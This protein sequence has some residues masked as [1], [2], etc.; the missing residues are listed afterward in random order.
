MLAHDLDFS[1][2]SLRIDIRCPQTLS[3]KDVGQP[4]SWPGSSMNYVK[5]LSHTQSSDGKPLCLS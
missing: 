4:M 3:G 2:F 1:R 5:S